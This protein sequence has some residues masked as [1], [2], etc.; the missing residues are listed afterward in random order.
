MA[1]DFSR[2]ARRCRRS[3]TIALVA[4]LC[5][6]APMPPSF[7]AAIADIPAGAARVWFYRD[8]APYVE[9]DPSYVRMNGAIVGLTEPGGVFYR[10]VAPGRYYISVDTSA[11]DVNQFPWVT[12][13]PG[14]VAYFKIFQSRIWASGGGASQNYERPTFY[15]RLIPPAIA[16]PPV[17]HSPP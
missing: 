11:Y 9:V 2:F 1:I 13:A 7:A 6:G 12:L 10:D 15:V 3:G 16:A 5:G 4:A 8:D 14:Q 17:P